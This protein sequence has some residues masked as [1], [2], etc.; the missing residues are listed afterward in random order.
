[1]HVISH[2]PTPRDWK[3]DASSDSTSPQADSGTQIALVPILG[4]GNDVWSVRLS[5]DL[6]SLHASDGR[7]VMM[8]PREDAARHVRFDHDL[9]R[10]H[11]LS[12]MLHEGL[13]SYR[14][15]CPNDVARR[16]LDWLPL[17]PQ[18]DLERERIASGVLVTLLGCIHLLFQ[19]QLFWG[20][21]VIFVAIGLSGVLYPRRMMTLLSGVAL[22]AMGFLLL[23]IAVMLGLDDALASARAPT[24]AAG[25]LVLLWSIQFFAR[26]SINHQLKRPL[27]EPLALQP[28]ARHASRLVRK[29]ALAAVFF[30]LL[31]AAYAIVVHLK[32]AGSEPHSTLFNDVVIFGG[33]S[34]L[35]LFSAVVLFLR[36]QPPYQE[37]KLTA[38]LLIIVA[39]LYAWGL[40]AG[41]SLGKPFA[42]SE[43]ILASGLLRFEQ[44]HVWA[45]LIVLLL[46][47]NRWFLAAADRE[48][49]EEL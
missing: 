6:F 28:G 49:Q 48:A 11:T 25:G 7:L 34:A 5:D 18:A 40:A 20:W 17:R 8:L 3:M 33:L 41:L 4:G 31:F 35:S 10:G 14:F 12:V 32:A 37:A 38:Q 2:R 1:M 36:Q 30:G 43:G 39:V 24:A 26:L 42:F 15:R 19:G 22:L 27:P 16:L 29:V 44:P 23:F 21:G 47:F 13:K 45:P 46:L 9:F